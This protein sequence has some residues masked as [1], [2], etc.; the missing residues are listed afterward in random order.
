MVS[1]WFVHF[2]EDL[3]LKTDDTGA[4]E[5]RFIMEVLRLKRGDLV[6]DAPCGAGRVA[7]HLARAGCQ[8]TGIDLNAGFI[9]RARRR[10]AGETLAADFR[11]LD[12]R[13]IDASGDFDAVYNWGG[14]F[15]YCT[16]EE[17]LDVLRRMACALKSGGRLLIDVPNRESLLRRFVPEARDGDRVNRRRWDASTQRIVSTWHV[18]DEEQQ[19]AF[20]SIR[21]YT[22]AQ[23]R[24]LLDEVGLCWERAYGGHD[25]SL[26]TRAS[27]RLIVVGRK[28]F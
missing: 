21:L 11:V 17:D 8:V 27:R 26:H 14:S 10:L 2:P 3:W 15:G 5:A 20:A 9:A 1:D 18:G 19:R 12:M 22:P 13:A 24:R 23:L 7:V 28:S 6:L 4:E 16:E 25:G